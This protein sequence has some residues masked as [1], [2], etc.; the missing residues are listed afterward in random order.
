[1]EINMQFLFTSLLVVGI[2]MSLRYISIKQHKDSGKQK[3][4]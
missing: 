1:M 3:H 4:T 2:L